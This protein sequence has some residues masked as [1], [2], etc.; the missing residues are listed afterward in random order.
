MSFSQMLGRKILTQLTDVVL[1]VQ[2]ELDKT[3][4][5]IQFQTTKVA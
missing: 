2:K 4:Q 1:M 3:H 5:T